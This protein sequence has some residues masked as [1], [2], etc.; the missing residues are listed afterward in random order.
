M[1][2][3]VSRFNTKRLLSQALCGLLLTTAASAAHAASSSTGL[4]S[5]DILQ[6]FNLVVL[7]N[8]T[9][10]SNVEGRT[11][12]GGALN[13]GNYATKLPSSSSNFAG[14]TVQGSAS[15]IHVQNQG[16]VI[17]GSLSNSIINNGS[18]A[19]LGSSSYS[20]F[21][22]NKD[23]VTYVAGTLTGGHI[24]NTKLTSL[25]QNSVLQ[26]EVTT[27]QNTSTTAMKS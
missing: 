2:Y 5:L 7:G 13:G 9:S 10:S 25:N 6:Q 23:N 3:I 11:Y 26:N 20:N 8:S 22:G 16:A 21:N 19:V 12:I 18:T 24:N 1:E 27:A 4:S 15:N 14:L 17:A